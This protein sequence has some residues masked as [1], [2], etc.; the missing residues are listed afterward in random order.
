MGGIASTVTDTMQQN[1]KENQKQMQQAQ[2]ESMCCVCHRLSLLLVVPPRL[3]CSVCRRVRSLCGVFCCG[4]M[5][6]RSVMLKQRELMAATE[7]ARGKERFNWYSAFAGTV[8]TLAVV[9]ALKTKNP[10]PLVPVLVLGFGWAYQYDM[11]YGDKM[12]RINAEASRLL[13]EEPGRFKPASGN[14]LV[15]DA[16]YDSLFVAAPNT[17]FRRMMASPSTQSIITTAPPTTTA[18]ATAASK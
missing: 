13:I 7:F 17:K 4:L 15:S 14:M 9:G 18:A 6:G 5:C 10:K 3:I 8:S 2:K 12:K 16:E 1:M 11:F